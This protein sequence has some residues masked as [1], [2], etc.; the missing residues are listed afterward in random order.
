M[1]IVYRRSR[2]EMPAIDEEIEE[3]IEEGVDVRYLTVP[4]EVLTSKGRVKGLRCVKTALGE[5]DGTGRRRPLPVSGSEHDI[6]VDTVIPALGQMADMEFMSGELEL[7]QDALRS[8]VKALRQPVNTP[9][10]WRN[11]PDWRWRLYRWL[12]CS[13]RRW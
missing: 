9:R 6:E 8:G 7:E 3:A 1:V 4:V 11:Q 13:R 5:P 10:R 2:Q 12:S